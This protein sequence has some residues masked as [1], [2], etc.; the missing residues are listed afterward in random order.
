MIGS[1]GHR[2]LD[3]AQDQPE[4]SVIDADDQQ[5]PGM[6]AAARQPLAHQSREVPDVAGDQDPL[7]AGGEVEQRRV[8]PAVKRSLLVDGSYVVATLARTRAT[9]R[10]ET[11]ASRSSRTR[12][13]SALMVAI[14][15]YSRWS[16]ASGRSFSAIAASISSGYSA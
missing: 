10:P 16:S 3:H 13:Y 12:R 11:W 2:S 5:A 6:V 8:V 15:G 1:L 4:L 14:A 7:L 9:A